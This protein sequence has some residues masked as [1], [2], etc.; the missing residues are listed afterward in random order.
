MPLTVDETAF[1]LSIAT[2]EDEH[3]VLLFGGYVLDDGVGKLFPS[4][5]LM[6]PCLMRAHGEGAVEQ[7]HALL[8][9]APQAAALR[10][11]TPQVA[12]DFL[13]DVLERRGKRHTVCHGEAEALSL[14]RLMV[15]VL[16]EDDHLELFKRAEVE[17]IEYLSRRGIACSGAVLLAHKVGELTEIGRIK[18]ALESLCPTGMYPYFHSVSEDKYFSSKTGI[19]GMRTRYFREEKDDRGKAVCQNPLS[20]T[21]CF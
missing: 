1:F 16:P 9:P 8:C 6:A 13:E 4:P 17:G 14:P 11:G 18:L 10:Y 7:Q 15:G 2:P 12:V 20:Q 3:H 19:T 5:S 21:P